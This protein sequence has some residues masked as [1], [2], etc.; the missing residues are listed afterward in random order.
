MLVLNLSCVHDHPFEGWFG[1]AE[2]FDDQLARGLISCPSCGDTGIERRPSAPRLNV[3][4]L[5]GA[6]SAAPAGAETAPS[7]AALKTQLQQVVREV[8]QR[9][10]DVGE[11]FAEE[12]R[13]M[14]YGE[15]Q[16][17]GIRGQTSLAEAL[18][19]REE[20]IVVMALPDAADEPRH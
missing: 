12:A 13:R 3:S 19:L 15:A 18:E 10:E 9:T 16:S 17:R 14:H 1:S 4:H 5:R 2:D 11:R 8:L 20:G 6:A 7:L